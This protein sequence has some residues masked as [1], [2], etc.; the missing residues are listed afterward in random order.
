MGRKRIGRSGVSFECCLMRMW[1]YWILCSV[2][3]HSFSLCHISFY[4]LIFFSQTKVGLMRSP[5]V[6]TLE[7]SPKTE[8]DNLP[9][10]LSYL[11]PKSEVE[12]LKSSEFFSNRLSK[13]GA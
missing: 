11:K 5:V 13:M 3:S 1:G 10:L 7:R 6:R 8:I 9:V 2:F 4:P 12:L